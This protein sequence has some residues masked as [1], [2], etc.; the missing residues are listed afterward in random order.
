VQR[1][2]E[3]ALSNGGFESAIVASGKEAVTFA[4]IHARATSD[5][6]FKSRRAA[7]S[8]GLPT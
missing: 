7:P 3:E 6:K 1:I 5:L 4:G 2:I 8:V